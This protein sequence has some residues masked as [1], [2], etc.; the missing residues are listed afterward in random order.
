[1]RNSS[2]AV[3]DKPWE[4]AMLTDGSRRQQEPVHGYDKSTKT[5]TVPSDGS[6][7][8]IYFDSIDCKADRLLIACRQLPHAANVSSRDRPLVAETAAV[9][10]RRSRRTRTARRILRRASLAPLRTCIGVTYTYTLLPPTEHSRHRLHTGWQNCA[11][12]CN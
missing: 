4:V 11:V 5:Q 12:N 9:P 3:A 10:G 2:Y 8:T 1:M 7:R 6:M